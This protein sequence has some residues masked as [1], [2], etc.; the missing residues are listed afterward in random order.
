MLTPTAE[1][2]S[3]ESRVPLVLAYNQ[4]NTGTKRILLENFEMLFSDPA[5]R[6]ICPEPP[7]LSYRRDRNLRDYLVHSA[8]RSD[9][10]AGTFACRH[11]RCLTCQHTKSQTILQSPKCLFTIRDRF[12]C[13]SEN[14]VYSIIC[15]RCGCLYIGETGRRLRE[16]FSERLRTVLNNS[17]GFPVAEHFNS[18]SHSLNDIMICGLKSCSGDNTRRK[19][20]EV[21]LIFELGTLKPNGL[22]INFSLFLNVYVAFNANACNTR[23]YLH[24]PIS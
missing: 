3:T 6:T 16:R 21:R 19:N 7:L 22:N 12:T 14:V 2:D 24:I 9:S 11:P 23:S 4:F 17:P 13:Q 20:Q 15:R 8:E 10:D 5:T 18:A 1:R